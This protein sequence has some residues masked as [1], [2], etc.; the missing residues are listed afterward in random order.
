LEGFLVYWNQ[1]KDG[2]KNRETNS[3]DLKNPMIKDIVEEKKDEI[4]LESNKEKLKELQNKRKKTKEELDRLEA[5]MAAVQRSTRTLIPR[6]IRLHDYC[7]MRWRWYY[8]WSRN[9]YSHKVHWVVLAAYIIGLALLFVSMLLAGPKPSQ[10][11]GLSCSSVGAG[12][13]SDAATWTSCG[14][15]VPGAADNAAIAHTVTLTGAVDI[16]TGTITVNSGGTLDTSATDYALSTAKLTILA[17][18]TVTAN[19]S[20]ITLSG[21]TVPFDRQ[22]TGVFTAGTSTV[23]FTANAA[24]NGVF[25]DATQT[26]FNV[27]ISPTITASR[28]YT[29]FYNSTNTL[30]IGGTFLI[31][32]NSTP[33]AYLLTVVEYRAVLSVTG[34]A[35]I[36]RTNSATASLTGGS[37][38]SFASLT[39]QSGGTFAP[40]AS[41][42]YITGNT[43]TPLTNNGTFTPG[44]S[45]INFQTDTADAPF[46]GITSFGTLYFTPTLTASRAWTIPAL[47][48]SGT[49][50]FY[51]APTAASALSLTVNLGGDLNL[52]ST[53]GVLTVQGSSLATSILNTDNVNNYAVTAG[54]LRIPAGGTVT[55]NGSIITLSSGSSNV[56]F[57]REGTGVFTAG[58]STLVFTSDSATSPVFYAATHNLYNVE[59]SPTITSSYTYTLCSSACT[60][61]IGGTFNINPQTGAFLLTVA[62]SSATLNVTGLA[63]IQKN[64]A[65]TT[66]SLTTAAAKTAS[67]GALTIASGGTYAPNATAITNISGDMSIASGGTYT[68]NGTF[69]FNGTVATTYEDLNASKQD[70]GTISITKTNGTPANNKLTLKTS[71]GNGMKVSILTISANNTLDLNTGGYT[72]E[73]ANVGATATV[74]TKTGT[75]TPGTS[76]VKYSAT[77]SG[78]DITITA[79]T[80]SNLEISNDSE[81]YVPGAAITCNGNLTVTAGTL[82]SSAYGITVKG[83]Y[84]TGDGTITMTGTT[85]FTLYGTGNFGGATNWTFNNLTFGVFTGGLGVTTA[86]GSG[87]I[88]VTGTLQISAHQVA[89]NSLN[90]GSKTWTLSGT[91][92]TPFS[93]Q[94]TFTANTSTII[95]SGNYASGDT[96]I[97]TKDDYGTTFPYYNLQINNGFETY[98]PAG[99][100]DVNG[101][102]T[103]TLGTLSMGAYNLNVA[104]DFLNPGGIFT[105]GNVGTAVVLDGAGGT[106]Q[107]VTGTNIFQ[108]LTIQAATARTVNFASGVVQTVSGTWTATG[109]APDKYLILGRDGGTGSDQWEITP[110]VGWSVDYVTPANSKNNAVDPINPTHY[111]DGGNTT[112]WFGVSN[113]PPTNDSLNFTNPY[114]S[115]IAIADNSTEWQFQAKVTDI[116]GLTDLNY[117]ML[118]MAN[119]SDSTTPYDSLRLKWLRSTNTFTLDNDS[120][121][122]VTLGTGSSSSSG[123]QWTINFKLIFNDSIPGFTTKDTNYAAELYSIDNSSGSDLDDYADIYK[124]TALSIS[125]ELTDLAGDPQDIIAFG[126]LL[127]GNVLTGTTIATVTTNY[128]GGYTLGASDNVAGAWSCLLHTIDLSTR[129]ADYAGT[130]ETPTQWLTGTGFG[131]SLYA[132]DTTKEGKWGTG[133]TETDSNNNYAGVPQG[134]TT[135]HTKA[136]S[137][138]SG[139]RSWIGYKL[140]VPNTQKTGDY[141]GI[142]TYTATG[143]LP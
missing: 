76:T 101:S 140:V 53:T 93:V 105:K 133:T 132:A 11:A 43:G 18:G 56:P 92:G 138:T 83:G 70:L 64:G 85:G 48:V 118:R 119:S 116:D 20:T 86:T 72:L 29:L 16:T 73:I 41:T 34:A 67:F 110:A 80:Y 143:V 28:Q 100:L 27:E 9:P 139:D 129:I 122:A 135:I 71:G 106:T 142:V 33:N 3:S 141:S 94:N 19:G 17:G 104:G 35:T 50:G 51:I 1:K 26:L 88:A 111:T 77:N 8:Q 22:S 60:L 49:N 117:V 102:L 31:N 47:T 66:S 63:T 120:Q 6:F 131:I 78:G 109:T 13:W 114:S 126:N 52:S 21:S 81:T 99:A 115:N 113:N 74:F 7:R 4:I 10:A 68:K 57:D 112:N 24:V 136:G 37:N 39:I 46:S 87:S 128:H 25:Y 123:N 125:L 55:A 38:M 96:T 84:V 89:T 75:L 127:P 134:A 121:S 79:A 14:G 58:T 82:S 98:V 91:T 137:P 5:D 97:D 62:V 44:T 130:I 69:T 36:Q 54:K 32:P 65:S 107:R 2:L 15:G 90:G 42:V 108:N 30:N 45:S 103:L 61:N 40:N 23:K 95:Y 12:N 59:M 124:V